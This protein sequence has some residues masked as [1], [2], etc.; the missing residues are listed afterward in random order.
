MVHSAWGRVL[1]SRCGR[2]NGRAAPD[3]GD[4]GGEGPCAT[5]SRGGGKRWAF[6]AGTTIPEGGGE[7]HAVADRTTNTI[8]PAVAALTVPSVAPQQTG[9]ARADPAART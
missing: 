9:I 4:G 2:P 5:C 6:P 7:R 8:A 1:G 3:W